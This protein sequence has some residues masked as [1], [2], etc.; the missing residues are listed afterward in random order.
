MS[1]EGLSGAPNLDVLT[2]GSVIYKSSAFISWT[3]RINVYF[4][5][6]PKATAVGS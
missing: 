4:L 6:Q 2:G 1:F 5:F 3:K